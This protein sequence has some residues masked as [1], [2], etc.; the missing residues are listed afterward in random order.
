[1]KQRDDHQRAGANER[2]G[3][4]RDFIA[5]LGVCTRKI[6]GTHHFAGKFGGKK[7]GLRGLPDSNYKQQLPQASTRTVGVTITPPP[8]ALQTK[9]GAKQKCAKKTALL[10]PTFNIIAREYA[11]VKQD[12]TNN[13]NRTTFI[14]GRGNKCT[15]G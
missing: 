2:R 7:E 14:I 12:L 6:H 3:E 9:G 4:G 10:T 15:I 5:H 8:Y 13:K 1:M 11:L